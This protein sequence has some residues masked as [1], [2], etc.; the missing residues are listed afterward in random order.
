MT[1][2]VQAVACPEGKISEEKIGIFKERYTFNGKEYLD[3][4]TFLKALSA[5]KSEEAIIFFH[6]C[7]SESDIEKIQSH[8][9]ALG[10]ERLNLGGMAC[11]CE[12]MP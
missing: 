9:V 12:S 2:F 7:G 11:L 1:F 3:L 10:V 5:I 8:L 6:P 4:N